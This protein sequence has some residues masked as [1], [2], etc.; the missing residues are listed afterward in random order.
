MPLSIRKLTKSYRENG[1]NVPVLSNVNLDLAQGELGVVCGPSGSGKTTLLN[2]IA[3]LDKPDSGEVIFENVRL[4]KTSE[5]AMARLRAGTIG[6]AFQNPNLVSHLTA[7]ENILLPTL[8]YKRNDLN[9]KAEAEK[10]LH[11]LGLSAKSKKFPQ[12]LSEGERKRVSIA[13]ALVTKPKL[14]LADE[15]TSNLDF[16]NS[17]TVVEVIRSAVE[18]EASALISTHDEDVAKRA[19]SLFRIRFGKIESNLEPICN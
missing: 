7:I 1:E 14:I 13:R 17:R 11:S 5:L 8:F 2:I 6:I 18:S 3:G 19:D 16:E 9:Y 4:D 15:P 10:L 12:K